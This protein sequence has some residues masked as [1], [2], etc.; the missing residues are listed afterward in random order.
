MEQSKENRFSASR[1]NTYKLCPAKYKWEQDVPFKPLISYLMLG[2]AVHKT[3]ELCTKSTSLQALWSML[4]TYW[5]KKGWKSPEQ[6]KECWESA[7]RCLA[8][9]HVNPMAKLSAFAKERWMRFEWVDSLFVG[10]IDRIDMDPLGNFIVTDYKTGKGPNSLQ[11]LRDSFQTVLYH[12]GVMQM[13]GVSFERVKIRYFFLEYG[14]LIEVPYTRKDAY[15]GFN[16][17][18]KVVKGIKAHEFPKKSCW[19]CGYCAYR[20]ICL[21]KD[22]QALEPAKKE[23]SAYLGGAV[24]ETIAKEIE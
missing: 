4:A 12:Y 6:E 10:K 24:L 23:P 1:L 3:L 19:L 13:F 18:Y 15:K 14:N 2:D 22:E 7:C 16:T 8:G 5:P 11:K 21:S 17:L 20:N 9:Y